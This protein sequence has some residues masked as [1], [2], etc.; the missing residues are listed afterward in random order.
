MKTLEEVNKE[1]DNRKQFKSLV[2]EL[3]KKH[4]A[5]EITF[6]QMD[7]RLEEFVQNCGTGYCEPN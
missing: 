7:K 2:R 3:C 1:H 4:A 6:D 5:G